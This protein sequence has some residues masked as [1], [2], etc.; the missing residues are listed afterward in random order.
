MSIAVPITLFLALHPLSLSLAPQNSTNHRP[1]HAP[2][3]MKVMTKPQKKKKENVWGSHD[4]AVVVGAEM[5]VDIAV[6]LC[7]VM[8]ITVTEALHHDCEGAP[9][10]GTTSWKRAS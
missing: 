1:W 9:R 10:G 3:Q 2:Q 6:E 8:G 4:V 5:L 7:K